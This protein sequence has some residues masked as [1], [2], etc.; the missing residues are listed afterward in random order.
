VEETDTQVAN[1]L[2]KMGLTVVLVVA[3]V[4]LNP[5]LLQ[6]RQVQEINLLYLLLKET[7]EVMVYMI[8]VFLFTVAEVA[9]PVALVVMQHQLILVKVEME[10]QIQ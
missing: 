5:L 10:Q 6:A 8:Q 1:H 2:L 9:E 4:H 7:M 3:V